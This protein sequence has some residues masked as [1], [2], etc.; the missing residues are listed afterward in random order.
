MGLW[1][2]QRCRVEFRERGYTHDY[3]TLMDAA[4][5]AEPLRSL[6]DPDD[7]RFFHPADM[8][9]EIAAFCSETGQPIP[10]TVGQFIRCCLESLALKYRLVLAWLEDVTG[11]RI[12]VVHIVGGGSQ[13]RL[14]NQLT[15]SACARP[16]VAGPVEATAIGNVLIQ[17]RTAG[18][19]GTL[20]DGRAVVRESFQLDYF[21]PQPDSRWLE[22]TERFHRLLR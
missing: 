9:A 4:Q 20:A 13:N 17:A 2:V 10:E 6:I 21:D 1:L 18:E 14:L 11:T 19:L 22:A 5:S 7:P 15:A 12:E 8:P 16:V 3:E